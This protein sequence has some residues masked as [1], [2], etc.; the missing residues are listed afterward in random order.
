VADLSGP[1]NQLR[2]GNPAEVIQ[3]TLNT[4]GMFTYRGDAVPI[5]NVGGRP[6]FPE[7]AGAVLFVGG[8]LICL[9]RWKQPACALMLIWF[10]VSLIPAMVTPFSPNFVRSMASWP[11]SFVFAGVAMNEVVQWAGRR[12]GV[13]S[14]KQDAGGQKQS[15]PASWSARHLAIALLAFILAWNAAL[16]ANDYFKQ[17]PT[18]DYVRFWQQATW[19]QAV[20][21]LNADRTSTPL[22]ASGLSIQDFDPQTFDLLGLRSDLKVKWFDCRNAMLYP[23]AGAITRYLIPAY[24]PCDTDLQTRFWHGAQ[25]I[26]Q[27]HWPDT[28]DAIFTLQELDGR[29]A[30]ASTGAQLVP[31]PVWIGGEAF[32]ARDPAG[33]LEPAHVPLDLNGLSLLSWETDR[34]EV[35]PGEVIDLFTYW[36][37][38]RPVA[39]PLKL[40]VHVTAPDGKI[41][42]QWDGLD[43]N[44]G[45]LEPSDVFVQRHRLELPGDLLSGPYR[46]SIGAYHPDSGQRLQAQLDGA[47][48]MD[49]IVLGTLTVEE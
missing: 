16:T 30:L 14:R 2:A 20:R 4:L 25:T 35:K 10:F 22:A 34:L 26:T 42:A 13:G 7:I 15:Y 44:S 19:T 3:S 24:L 37:I 21:A 23:Q 33:D 43:V 6:V 47:R 48:A 5:Y 18:G 9:W 39:P 29:A 31:R 45:T 46:V 12:R 36:E 8:L 38:A 17:W 41:V 1:L 28:G 27:P 11:A 40:F 32:D 49:S